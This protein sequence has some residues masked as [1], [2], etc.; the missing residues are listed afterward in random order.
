MQKNSQP[1][2]WMFLAGLLAL[3]SGCIIAPEGR[4]HDGYWDR[5]HDR[6]WHGGGWHP[7]AEHGEYCR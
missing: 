1:L 6:Y 5:D 3:T 7:C 2:K 4:Y